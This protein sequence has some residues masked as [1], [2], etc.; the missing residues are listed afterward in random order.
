M[1]PQLITLGGLIASLAGAWGVTRYQT[2]SHAVAI[3]KLETAKAQ[4]QSEVS[5]LNTDIAVLKSQTIGADRRI[6]ESLGAIRDVIA[7][8]EQRVIAHFDSAV[9]ALRGE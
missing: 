4:L 5:R 3:E 1:D 2:G 8:S 9:R 7:Q 6:T